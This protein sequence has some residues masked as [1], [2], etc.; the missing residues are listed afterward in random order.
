MELSNP[1]KIAKDTYN[2]AT[3]AVDKYADKAQTAV[4]KYGDKA[5]N[6]VERAGDK[7]QDFAESHSLMDRYAAVRDGAA[8]GYDT[9]I[10]TV[11]KYP[12]YAVLG[13]TAIGLLA[14]MLIARRRS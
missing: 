13:S 14:G 2:G 11:K 9:A 7:V 4:E 1:Q 10:S 8:E 3:K 6:F 5:Q 12:L